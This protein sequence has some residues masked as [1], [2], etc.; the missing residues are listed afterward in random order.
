MFAIENIDKEIG[1]I[2]AR[3]VSWGSDGQKRKEIPVTLVNCDE[4]LPG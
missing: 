2:E 4:L 3:R 1:T